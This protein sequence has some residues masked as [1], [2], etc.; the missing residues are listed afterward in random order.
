MALKWKVVPDELIKLVAK[1]LAKKVAEDD[2]HINVGLLGSKAILDALSENGY[3]QLAFQLATSDSYPS[4]GY[5][6]K[7]GA[8]TLFENWN[9]DAKSDL[10]QNH[11]MFGEI[12]AWF[13]KGLGG[14]YPDELEPGFKNVI[15]KPN[16]VEGLNFFNSQH[17]GPYGKIISAWERKGKS[18]I[19]KVNIP[20]NSSS[21]VYLSGNYFL[22]GNRQLEKNNR[23]SI[24][25]KDSGTI[26]L[27]LK[28]G[29]Y[30]FRVKQ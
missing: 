1:R 9:L 26:E 21:T 14:I 4:W 8:T 27:Q 3:S 17:T 2:M 12:S 30:E 29:S 6:I 24:I 20:C 13:Y 25:K 19:Y 18:I 22:E 28:S 5:W 23:I 11:I 15:L 10:S 7:N 16:F